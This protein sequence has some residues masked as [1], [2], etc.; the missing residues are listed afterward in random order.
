MTTL[1]D[2]NNFFDNNNVILEYELT[3]EIVESYNEEQQE[4]YN[5]LQN[6]MMYEGVNNISCT[7]GLTI[8]VKYKMYEEYNA[9]NNGNIQSRPIIKITKVNDEKIDVSIN[10]IRFKYDFKSDKYVEIDCVEKE[11]KYEGLNRNRQLEIDYE[12]PSLNIGNN[13]ILAHS[14]DCIIEMKRKDRW[15]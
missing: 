12:F 8:K 6:F 3:E 5:K 11:V 10:G 15:L 9:K 4:A 14:G 2:W 13:E 7:E 1:E